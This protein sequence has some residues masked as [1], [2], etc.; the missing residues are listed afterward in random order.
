MARLEQPNRLSGAEHRV[1]V[2]VELSEQK[3]ATELLANTHKTI[4]LGVEH[5]QPKV[6]SANEVEVAMLAI[7]EG[8]IVLHCTCFLV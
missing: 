3:N 1:G 4:G 5:T 7:S 6:A 2:P 8:D